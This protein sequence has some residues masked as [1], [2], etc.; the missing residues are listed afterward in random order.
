MENFTLPALLLLMVV[1]FFFNGWRAA[2]KG[3]S[4][5]A[6]CC[7]GIW[8]LFFLLFLPVA[9]AEKIPDEAVRR[10]RRSSG[11]M[12]GVVATVLTVPSF[13][14]ALLVF[15]FDA[16]MRHLDLLQNLF[17]KLWT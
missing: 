4:Y 5:A 2:Q 7:G 6:W 8:G 11:N 17:R 3:Y 16:V 9:T 13:G 15:G 1:L 12:L 14:V 10:S